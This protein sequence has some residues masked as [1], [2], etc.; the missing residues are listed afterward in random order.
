MKGTAF[1]SEIKSNKNIYLEVLRE[2]WYARRK[3]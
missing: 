3:P 2:K 1:L